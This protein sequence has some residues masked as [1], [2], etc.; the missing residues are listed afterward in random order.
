MV[1][2][3]PAAVLVMSGSPAGWQ[4]PTQICEN[5]RVAT[6]QTA[7]SRKLPLRHQPARIGLATI[8]RL[9][10]D[11]EPFRLRWALQHWPYPIA[12]L[13]R[14]LLPPSMSQPATFLEWET[15]ILNT[16]WDRLDI[17]GRLLPAWPESSPI[18]ATWSRPDPIA[19]EQSRPESS[20]P[21]RQ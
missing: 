10:V 18:E 20:R 19:R 2:M 3:T 21:I 15:W 6:S 1:M 13:I 14:S 9:L 4:K 11:T 5:W 12:K 16:A 7:R 8:A 17:E